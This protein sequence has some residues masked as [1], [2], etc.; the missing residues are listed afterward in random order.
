MGVG[1][2]FVMP[3]TLSIL[4]S[5]FRR[6]SGPRRSPSGPASRVGAAIGPVASGL[7][8]DHFWYGSVFLVNLPIIAMALVAG[9]VL[10][11]KSRRLQANAARSGRCRAVDPRSRRPRLR[12]HRRS[13]PRL[14][15]RRVGCLVRRRRHPAR[16]RA[17]G[18]AQPASDARPAPVPEPPLRR[19]VWRHHVGVLRHVRLVLH[20][21][22]VLPGR[23]W[24]EPAERCAAPASVLGGD[25]GRRPN[26]PSWSA[27]SAPTVSVPSASCRSPSG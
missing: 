21:R 11:P 8:L 10:V 17:L 15:E 26:T 18:V 13:A 9:Y 7:L 3:S 14:A 27:G 12:H 2:A 5:V 19:L 16:L 25:D 22:P 6:A 1:A 20:A 24:L 23:P 4:A